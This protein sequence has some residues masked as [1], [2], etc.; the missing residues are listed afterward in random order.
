M[1]KQIVYQK[2]QVV[3]GVTI[4][5]THT[6]P[7]PNKSGI[8]TMIAY[9]CQ[10]AGCGKRAEMSKGICTKW[11]KAQSPWLCGE[12]LMVRAAKKKAASRKYITALETVDVPEADKRM[13]EHLGKMMVFMTV[14]CSDCNV[15][16]EKTAKSLRV[17]E[18][19]NGIR[20][21]ACVKV[22]ESRQKK[23]KLSLPKQKPQ[24]GGLKIS[25]ITL[26]HW[27][28]LS[29]SLQ[30][31]AQAIV[32]RHTEACQRM[33]V[34]IENLDRLFAEAMEMAKLEARHSKRV[35]AKSLQPVA[36]YEPFRQ[37]DQYLSP[38]AD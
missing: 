36:P 35:S 38:R 4:L 1:G 9:H 32:R 5:A 14:P 30:V 29:A 24:P 7:H 22:F 33:N 8:Q 31:S 23:A 15:R 2:G 12:C 20:C 37:Y 21:D 34:P 10:A 3:A 13:G 28:N 6:V 25:E 26:R 16:F 17:M 19:G 27:N 11:V 18:G